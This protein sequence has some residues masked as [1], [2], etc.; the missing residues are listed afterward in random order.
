MLLQRLVSCWLILLLII[1]N[2]YVSLFLQLLKVQFALSLSESLAESSNVEPCFASTLVI[3]E[4]KK[5]HMT[6][7]CCWF[8]RH[9]PNCGLLTSLNIETTLWKICNSVGI[10][11]VGIAAH[12]LRIVWPGPNSC[13]TSSFKVR[14]KNEEKHVPQWCKLTINRL[15]LSISSQANHSFQRSDLYI[16]RFPQKTSDGFR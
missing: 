5:A 10:S 2:L 16:S 13:E 1:P 4:T 12:G 6:H 11:Q 15:Q 8:S 9:L 14:D 3:E 7:A